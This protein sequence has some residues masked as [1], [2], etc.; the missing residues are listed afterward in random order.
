MDLVPKLKADIQKQASLVYSNIYRKDDKV[1]KFFM[2]NT[3]RND[4]D[5]KVGMIT[6]YD[7]IRCCYVAHVQKTSQWVSSVL[8]ELSVSPE[9]M[10]PYIRVRTLTYCPT[11]VCDLCQIKLETHFISSIATAAPTITF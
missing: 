4:L 2:V 1:N 5:G 11:A 6:S 9:N 10:E 7:A 3:G 8:M